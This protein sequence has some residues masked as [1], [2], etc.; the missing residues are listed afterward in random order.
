MRSGEA[1]VAVAE[2]IDTPGDPVRVST[3]H[4]YHGL[5]AVYAGLGRPADARNAFDRARAAYEV[6]EHHAVIAFSLL[7]E[8]RDVVIPYLTDCPAERRRLAAEAEAA[9]AHASGALVSGIITCSGRLLLAIDGDWDQALWIIAET[10][11]P[12]NG[13]LRREITETRAAIAY[14][15]GETEVVRAQIASI[16]PEGPNMPPG[17]R[18]HQEALFLQRLAVEVALDG[19]DLDQARAPGSIRRIAGSSGVAEYSAG[20]RANSSGLAGTAPPATVQLLAP[21]LLPLAPRPGLRVNRWR[22]SAPIAFWV[23]LR[24][25]QVTRPQRSATPD[26]GPG[27]CGRMRRAV[28]ARAHCLLALVE[29]C[30]ATGRLDNAARLIGDVRS[31]CLRQLARGPRSARAEALDARLTSSPVAFPA[32]LSAREVEVLRLV[33]ED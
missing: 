1:F 19:G 3:G 4:A 13:L 15:Q 17:S 22:S 11:P 26:G 7:T 28:R 16:L 18:I 10:P 33:T 8:M 32:G 29:L 5:G 6:L 14:G 24:S 20:R 23:C 25:M 2:T 21:A 30:I 31:I 12:G 9:I 27:A